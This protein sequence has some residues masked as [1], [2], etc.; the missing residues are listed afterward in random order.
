M[1]TWIANAIV[2]LA[3]FISACYAIWSLSPR[4]FR[5]RLRVRLARY[6]PMLRL[7]PNLKDAGSVGGCPGCGDCKTRIK[8]QQ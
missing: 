5:E 4:T 8:R 6:L 2:V 7:Y 3:V 1:S